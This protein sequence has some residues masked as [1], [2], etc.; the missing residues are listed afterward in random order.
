[1]GALNRYLRT[2]AD[3]VPFL[4]DLSWAVGAVAS[5]VA[6]A[7]GGGVILG[8]T[9]S[10]TVGILLALGVL[11]AL[12]VLGGV[13]L[14]WQLDRV[15]TGGPL[16]EIGDPWWK[17]EMISSTTRITPRYETA[18]FVGF[19][20]VNRGVAPAEHVWAEL[21]F[22][23]PGKE[24]FLAIH[25]RPSHAPIAKVGEPFEAPRFTEV[26]LPPNS[27]PEPFDVAA[28]FVEDGRTYAL[29]T[30]AVVVGGR[31]DPFGIA[32]T[33]F[34]VTARVRG[35]GGIDLR[36]SWQCGADSDF[37]LIPD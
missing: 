37:R 3:A 8:V 6:L 24:P 17:T 25:A 10:P 2:V 23:L 21:T 15:D 35:S 18:E 5:L 29:N 27:K 12:S 16:V 20:I 11:L 33:C 26:T 32:G 22:S 9:V 13:R 19:N 34:V 7:L 36:Q 1:M 4:G 30:R 31:H 14:A 28:R